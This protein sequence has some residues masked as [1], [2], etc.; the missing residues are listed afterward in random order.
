MIPLFYPQIHKSAIRAV[1]ATLKTKWLSQAHQVNEFEEQIQRYL[2]TDSEVITTNSGTSALHLAYILAGIKE[3]DEVLTPVLTCVATNIP[4]LYLKAKPVFVDIGNDLN[5]DIEDLKK[6]IT[7]KTKAIVVVDFGGTP[8]NLYDIL[9]IGKDHNI[10]VIED[11]AQ[12]F[13]AMY[14]DRKIGDIGDFICFSFQAI[15]NLTTG[16]GGALVISNPDMAERARRLRWFGIERTKKLTSDG[17]PNWGREIT[18]GITEIGYKY[19]MNDIQASIGKENLKYL[20]KD[21]YYKQRI[22][23]YYNEELKNVLGIKL[24]NVP[25][26]KK[27]SNWLYTILVD[28]R[29]KFKEKMEEK[30]IEVN[31]A[32]IRNDIYDIFGGQKLDL[33]NM[34]QIENN[35]ISI[36]L[37]CKLKWSE[38]KYIVKNI[39]EGW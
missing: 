35:Y 4:L 1:K 11:A 26:Y 3:G 30:E 15:K 6:K 14:G 28:D 7:E 21:L 13:G 27:S 8:A 31:V 32:H 5:I 37:H 18:A 29:D 25:F 22:V 16:D 10:P 20:D 9:Q 12:S 38:V 23:D 36:P 2:N 34:N 19:N 17:Q 24:L 39:Q 33:L